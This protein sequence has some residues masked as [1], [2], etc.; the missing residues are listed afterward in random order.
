MIIDYDSEED[1]TTSTAEPLP[2]FSPDNPTNITV[3]LGST[4]FLHCKVT[5]LNDK[6]VGGFRMK[7]LVFGNI[8]FN[9]ET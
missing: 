4:A 8:F 1:T 2:F 9:L 3:H 5:L 7:F 6:T